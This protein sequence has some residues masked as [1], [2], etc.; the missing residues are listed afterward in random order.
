MSTRVDSHQ[1]WSFK[2]IKNIRISL[3]L[4]SHKKHICTGA[5]ALKLFK[6]KRFIKK[7]YDNV[8][9]ALVK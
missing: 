9:Y 7:M 4:V 3:I 2:F 8:I 1:S 6:G 5:H